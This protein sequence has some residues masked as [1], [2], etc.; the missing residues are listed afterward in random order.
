MRVEVVCP[1]PGW[2][3]DQSGLVSA[4]PRAVSQVLGSSQCART[5]LVLVPRGLEEAPRGGPEV[6]GGV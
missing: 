6:S 5:E 4:M 1:I 3:G 2:G